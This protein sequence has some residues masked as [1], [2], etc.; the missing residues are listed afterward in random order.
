M[1]LLSHKKK[2]LCERLPSIANNF[3]CVRGKSCRETESFTEGLSL[4]GLRHNCTLCYPLAVRVEVDLNH[5]RVVDK[6]ESGQDGSV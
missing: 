5:I 4:R 1:V 2:S 3:R 6:S